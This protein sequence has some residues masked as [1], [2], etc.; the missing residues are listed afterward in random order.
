MERE[1]FSEVTVEPAIYDIEPSNYK[2]A[3]EP[4]RVRYYHSMIDAK[5]LNS[6]VDYDK[7]RKVVII[8]ILSYDPFE[9]NRMVYIIKSKCSK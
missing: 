6:G 2:A 3:S 8:M 9:E 4:K 5:L 7:L 1:L